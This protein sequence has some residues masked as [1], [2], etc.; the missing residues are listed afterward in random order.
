MST[1]TGPP[2]P[3]SRSTLLYSSGCPRM[4]TSE[5]PT[6]PSDASA[7]FGPAATHVDAATSQRWPTP[8]W[9]SR[10][11]P[12]VVFGSSPVHRARKRSSGPPSMTKTIELHEDRRMTRPS[13]DGYQDARVTSMVPPTAQPVVLLG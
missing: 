13:V 2:S 11:H 9:S 3:S 7:S 1:P 10:V 12:A 5:P 8:H 6:F 4:M